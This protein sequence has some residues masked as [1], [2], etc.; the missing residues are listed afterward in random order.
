MKILFLGKIGD[1]RCANAARQMERMGDV[2]CFNGAWGDPLP[3]EARDWTGDLIISY[4]SSWVVPQSLLDRATAINFHP[5]TP[6]YPGI[7]CNNFALYENA[8]TYGATCH[9]MAAKV[10]TGRV[11]KVRRFPVAPDETV[12]TLIEKTYEAQA[13]L[14]ADVMGEFAKTGTF[15]ESQERWTRQ[16]FTRIEFEALRRIEPDMTA[17]EVQRRVRAT[18]FPPY[19]PYIELHGHQFQLHR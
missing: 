11:I 2:L 5:A 18:D 14:F 19:G 16:P 4:L 10:D 8:K 17:E 15:P 9:H 6:E 1:E 12:A 7:G 13:A 3:K